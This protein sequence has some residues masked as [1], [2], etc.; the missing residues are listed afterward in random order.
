MNIREQLPF[1]DKKQSAFLG[2]LLSDEN[3][4][5]Q[6]APKVRPEWFSGREG[7]IRG[8]VFAAKLNFFRRFA[9]PPSYE[10]LQDTPEFR[11]AVAGERTAMKVAFQNS[12]GDRPTYGLDSL[13][14]EL[15]LWL[16]SRLF[17]TGV[18]A[19]QDLFNAGKIYEA[20]K[21]VDDQIRTIRTQSFQGSAAYDFTMLREHAAR[22]EL[23]TATA[24]TFGYSLIDKLLLPEAHGIGCLLPGDTTIVLAPTNVGKTTCVISVAAANL[25]RNLDRRR[26]PVTGAYI[27]PSIDVLIV[28]H[29]GVDDDIAE[30]IAMSVLNVNRAQYRKMCKATEGDDKLYIDSVISLLVQ[31]LKYL[32]MNKGALNVE[33]VS[34]AISLEQEQRITETGKGYN[35]VI[36]DYPA[37]LLSENMQFAQFQK[38]NLDEYT[39]NQFVQLALHYKFHC[40]LLIQSNRIGAKINRGQKG[41]EE[42]LLTMEDANEAF[43]PMQIAT[44]VLTVNRD[45]WSMANDFLTYLNCKSRG[46]ETGQAIVCKSDY[47]HAITHSESLGGFWYK[48]TVPLGSLIE[49]YYAQFKGEAIPFDQFKK[50]VG[51]PQN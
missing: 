24:L 44:N 46:S 39:Y 43:G 28:T 36:D 3:F 35:L 16:H 7:D 33:D 6:C 37:K 38:R 8:K 18:E 48:G 17:T 9:R 45:P 26:N 19:A 21:L 22:R 2:W 51:N 32:P 40:L 13:A 1:N 49:S 5:K 14:P 31:H 27:D 47:A 23:E 12:L 30:K 29:E 4:F 50:V 15:T 11:D 42:R 25:R 10:E 34:A 41:Q 20:I